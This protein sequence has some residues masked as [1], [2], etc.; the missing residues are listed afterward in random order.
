MPS[1]SR[2]CATTLTPRSVQ[3]DP[4]PITGHGGWGVSAWFSE[5][6]EES[7][8]FR[9]RLDREVQ[10]DGITVALVGV[11]P[12]T[13]GAEKND[14]TIRKDIGFSRIHGWRKIIKVNKFAFRAT[15]V[16]ELRQAFDPIGLENDQW[17]ADAFSEADLIVPCW[18]PLSKLPKRLRRRWIE[19]RMIA[20]RSGKPMMCLGAAGDGQPLHTLTL[21]YST[22]LVPWSLAA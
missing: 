3:H 10:E 20:Q 18:G 12:S 14:Q 6:G 19:V 9:W 17:L 15:D 22:P 11:N 21:A 4:A 7:A 5:G 2:L 16:T 13:A 1:R 8:T